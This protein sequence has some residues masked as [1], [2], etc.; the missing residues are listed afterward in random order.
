MLMSSWV[1]AAKE[2]LDLIKCHTLAPAKSN[3]H[4]EPGSKWKILVTHNTEEWGRLLARNQVP[5]GRFL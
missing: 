1:R 2:M 3:I 4:K 5:S